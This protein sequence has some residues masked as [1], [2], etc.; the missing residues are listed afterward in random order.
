MRIICKH[1]GIIL[2]KY[3]CENLEIE[4]VNELDE[5]TVD[6]IISIV[7][8][9]PTKNY[10]LEYGIGGFVCDEFYSIKHIA[11]SNND[12]E[13]IVKLSKVR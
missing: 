8:W 7:R 5:K 1:N 13:I 9:R 3:H 12:T 10:D 6:R 2:D 11:F 4:N